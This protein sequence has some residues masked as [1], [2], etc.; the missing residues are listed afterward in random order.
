M[1]HFQI[2]D[3]YRLASDSRQWIIQKKGIAKGK[4][5]AEDSVIWNNL[6]YYSSLPSAVQAAYGYFQRQS[7][8]DN[9][10]D[11][12]DDSRRLIDKFTAIFSPKL[13]IEEK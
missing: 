10:L 13:H 11:F 6:L 12:M 4:D 8:A 5:G 9:I 2:N 1:A 7:E 3:D